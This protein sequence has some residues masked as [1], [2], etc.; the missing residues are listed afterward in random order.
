MP[1][2]PCFYPT[3]EEFKKPFEY[4]DSIRAVAEPY[5]LCRIRPPKGW[6]PPY[7]IDPCAF[8]FKTRIQCIHEL[9]Y[10]GSGSKSNSEWRSSFS[11]FLSETGRKWKANPMICGSDVDLPTLHRAVTKRGGYEAV[12]EKRLWKEVARIVQVCPL[13]P[14]KSRTAL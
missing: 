5:G 14:L 4:I 8:K 10:R 6:K 12:V 7:A 13:F 11:S 3:E 1:P 9:C 2:A